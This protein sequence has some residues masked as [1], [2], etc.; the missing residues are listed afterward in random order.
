MIEPGARYDIVIDFL[1]YGHQRIIMKNIAGDEPFGGDVV[2]EGP[3]RQGTGFDYMDRIMA[4]DVVKPFDHHVPDNFDAD[5]I[6]FSVEFPPV[7]NSRR[8]GLF[9]GRDAFGRLQPLLGTIDKAIDDK[10]QPVMWPEN[11]VYKMAGLAGKQMEGTMGWHEPTTEIVR[12]GETELWEIWNLSAGKFV[13]VA[14][15]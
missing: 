1:H 4:F 8:L 11:E 12:I 10:G 6:S 5:K 9:E 2:L 14:W 7:D 3:D 15:S 13:N